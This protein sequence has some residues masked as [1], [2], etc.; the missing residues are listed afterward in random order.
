MLR[1]VDRLNMNP[2]PYNPPASIPQPKDE[3]TKKPALV[4]SLS[5]D[6]DDEQTLKK[7]KPSKTAQNLGIKPITEGFNTAMILID[8]TKDMLIGRRK[9]Q[10]EILIEDNTVSREHAKI[11][12]QGDKFVL[13]DLGSSAG[14]FIKENKLKLVPGMLIEVGYALLKILEAYPSKCKIRIIDAVDNWGGK[15]IEPIHG[16]RIG[17]K[18]GLEY[19]FP[20]DNYMSSIHAHFKAEPD[21]MYL[22]D[23]GSS[24]GIWR[25]LN[26]EKNKSGFQPV[27]A[28][29]MTIRFGAKYECQVVVASG[30]ETNTL[31]RSKPMC[32]SCNVNK[33]NTAVQPCGHSSYCSDCVS[34]VSTCSC[35][36]RITRY[37]SVQQLSLIHI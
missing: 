14:T 24:N 15:E 12:S 23:N 19:S 17:R 36:L 4:T 9:D 3:E 20:N 33:V 5:F 11:A 7:D 27:L 18:A 1:V 35:G 8:K 31:R 37:S 2:G 21:G 32:I 10:C 34:K 28:P 22:I 25:R 30:D 6:I 13:M 16:H 29:G 26:E